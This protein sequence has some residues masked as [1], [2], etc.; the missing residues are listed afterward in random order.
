MNVENR[1]TDRK[2]NRRE[3]KKLKVSFDRALENYVAKRGTE[4]ESDHMV[5]R[6][7]NAFTITK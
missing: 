3:N 7:A 1:R 4:S 5:E 2:K 6:M